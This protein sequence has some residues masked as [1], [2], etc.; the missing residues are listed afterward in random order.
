[1]VEIWYSKPNILKGISSA[2]LMKHLR[3]ISVQGSTTYFDERDRRHMVLLRVLREMADVMSI[4][5][6]FC[7][8]KNRIGIRISETMTDNKFKKLA[9]TKLGK[10]YLELINE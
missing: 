7:N 1:M 10:S 5:Y 4:K 6:S 2:A 8:Y 9:E 3:L